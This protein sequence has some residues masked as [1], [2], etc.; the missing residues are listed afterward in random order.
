VDQIDKQ[1]YINLANER[2]EQYLVGKK[3]TRK[4]K[5]DKPM[6]ATTTATPV[7]MNVYQKL[8]AARKRFLE[9]DVKKSGVNRFADFKYFELAD[10]VPAKTHIFTELGLIDVVSFDVDQAIAYLYNVDNPEERLVFCSPMR[11]LSTVSQTGKNKMNELQGLGA[12]ETYQRRYLYMMILDIVEADSFD[13]TS[14]QNES[15]KSQNVTEKPQK[16]VESTN[17][18]SMNKESTTRPASQSER[19][20]VKKALTNVDG[21]ADTAQVNAI[22][23]ALKKLREKDADRYEGYIG[24]CQAKIPTRK[25]PDRTISK[26]DADDMLIA[27]GEKIEEE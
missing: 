10:I 1:F 14:G 26:K 4:K 27:I 5:E 8:I 11:P 19:E 21:N 22:I 23:R 17:V 18:V 7:Q 2:V 25:N 15:T 12:E 20:E 3:S 24:E 16:P 13:A 9:M 6:A